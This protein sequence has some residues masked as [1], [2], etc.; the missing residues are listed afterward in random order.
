MIVLNNKWKSLW[1]DTRYFIISGGRGSSKSFGVGTF[2][3]LLSFEKGHKIL[4]TRQTMTSAHLSII[5]EF[6]EKIQLLESEDKF[7]ITKTD[8]LNL[9]NSDQ[10]NQYLTKLFASH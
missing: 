2:T 10:Q 7:E 4:F 3:S 1:N 6:Q 8:I 9:N 5:P